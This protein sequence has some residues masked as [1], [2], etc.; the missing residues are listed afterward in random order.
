M[1]LATRTASLR[2]VKKLIGIPSRESQIQNDGK[3]DFESLRLG[4]S[5]KIGASRAF[6]PDVI[7]IIVPTGRDLAARIFKRI[8]SMTP[9]AG[10]CDRRF[11][12]TGQKHLLQ[13]T[14]NARQACM[15]NGLGEPKLK[16]EMGK[17]DSVY[18]EKVKMR[19]I[20]FEFPP[21]VF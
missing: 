17:W 11:L 10:V 20:D 8:G 12:V 16:G 6:T 9:H 14:K 3:Q 4:R 21:F 19:T 18:A 5:L 2:G 7:L 13:E 1:P 15:A